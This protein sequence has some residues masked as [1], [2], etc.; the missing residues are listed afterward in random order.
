MGTPS[1]PALPAGLD[2]KHHSLGF[3]VLGGLSLS[4]V[5][6]WGQIVLCGGGQHKC[7][8]MLSC[9]PGHYPLDS[10]SCPLPVVVP[11]CL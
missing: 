1:C 9:I 5:D 4:P 2:S 11:K 7:Y 10:A 3:S 8:R 6:I